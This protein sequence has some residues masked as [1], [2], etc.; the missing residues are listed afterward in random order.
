M[1]ARRLLTALWEEV[2]Y[3]QKSLGMPRSE[4]PQIRS[5]DV[6]DFLTFLRSKG[7]VARNEDVAA[8]ELFPTQREINLD[9]TKTLTPAVTSTKRLLV[10]RDGYILDGHHRWFLA[11]QS[12]H[13]LPI[14][15]LSADIHQLLDLASQFPKTEY[16]GIQHSYH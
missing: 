15:R 4:M 3:P 9:K 14:V 5:F 1:N 6:P 12:G 10:S 7:V 11:L 16:K 13:S 2:V 8:A